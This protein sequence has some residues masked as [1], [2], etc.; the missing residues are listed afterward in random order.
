MIRLVFIDVDG[1]LVGSSGQVLPEVWA[2]AERARAAGLHLALS[3]GRPAFGVSR[4]YATRLD[5]DGWHVFQNGA[6]ILHVGRDESRSSSVP[7]PVV[8]SLV[9]RARQGGYVLEV[10]GDR[11]YVVESDSPLAR[12]HAA[13]LGV[14][15]AR[16]SLDA[17]P[18]PVVRCQW[19]A[20]REQ[21]PHLL[22]EKEPD[23][24]VLAS[25]SPVMP[26]AMFINMT[27]RGATKASAMAKVAE[28]AG[29][30][31]GDVMFVGDGMND[32]EGLQTVGYPVAMGNGEPEVRRAART[33]VSRVDDGGLVEALEIAIGSRVGGSPR[34]QR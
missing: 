2:A 5:P 24:E 20:T 9:R 29:V 23:L 4:T 10:Y 17:L 3:S 11:Q 28:L 7:A 14:P 26:D 8:E 19:V 27:A 12:G 1:T 22:A 6:S 32:L 31:L 34:G 25:T 21:T 16:G 15:F 18:Q 33:V 13:L 30:D